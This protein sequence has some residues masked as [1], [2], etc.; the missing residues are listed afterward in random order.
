MKKSQTIVFDYSPV[1]DIWINCLQWNISVT[2]KLSLSLFPL[3]LTWLDVGR[4]VNP[5]FVIW[6]TCV[7]RD[8]TLDSNTLI[9]LILLDFL[10]AL[11]THIFEFELNATVFMCIY[12][13]LTKWNKSFTFKSILM[14]DYFIICSYSTFKFE[15]SQISEHI[16]RADTFTINN[17]I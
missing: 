1:A 3:V 7:D 16:A 14:H 10:L 2:Q 4:I 15:D 11:Q 12:S 13:Q 17:V 6:F 8:M 9:N 5:I